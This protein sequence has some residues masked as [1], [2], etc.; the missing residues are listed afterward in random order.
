MIELKD[1]NSPQSKTPY[2]ESITFTDFVGNNFKDFMGSMLSTSPKSGAYLAH[3]IMRDASKLYR[4]IEVEKKNTTEKRI[5]YAPCYLLKQLQKALLREIETL[6]Q[7]HQAAHGFRKG[8]SNGT[9]ARMV[10]S[11]MKTTRYTVINQDLEKAFPTMKGRQIRRI[12]RSLKFTAWQVHIAA[13]I[14][15]YKGELATGSPTSPM[16]LNL[17]LYKLDEKLSAVAKKHGG[18]FVRYADDLTLSINT[19]KQKVINKTK[20][21]MKKVI[22]AENF[23]PH[24]HKRKV[25][26]IGIDSDK[27]ETVGISLTKNCTRPPQRQRRILFHIA[28]AFGLKTTSAD[29]QLHR[30][31]K[32][33]ARL[34]EPDDPLKWRGLGYYAYFISV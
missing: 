6:T 28:K 34:A 32:S 22:K 17:A 18:T 10:A 20:A 33:V 30:K 14:C 5:C 9:A 2:T 24:P 26:R 15:S 7:P 19:H 13:K 16:L 31:V 8:R 27:A 1:Q 29:D 23:V 12:F 4:V 25:T 3:Q 11:E 21:E